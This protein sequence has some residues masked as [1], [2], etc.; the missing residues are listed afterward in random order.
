MKN[1]AY[2]FDWEKYKIIAGAC[3]TDCNGWLHTF[4]MC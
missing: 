4:P 3:E 1:A 2:E